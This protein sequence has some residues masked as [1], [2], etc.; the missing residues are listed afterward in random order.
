MTRYEKLRAIAKA[1]R[2]IH[3]DLVVRS[4]NEAARQIGAACSAI[5]TLLDDV[6]DTSVIASPTLRAYI[7]SSVTR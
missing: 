7:A 1:L 4:E 5:E 6:D 3:G 2:Q